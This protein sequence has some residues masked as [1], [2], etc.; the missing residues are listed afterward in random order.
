[1]I[2]GQGTLRVHAR[3]VWE[4]HPLAGALGWGSG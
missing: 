1:M 4:G 3:R 2:E